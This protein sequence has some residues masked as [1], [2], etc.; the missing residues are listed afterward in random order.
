MSQLFVTTPHFFDAAD[1]R[2]FF[3]TY[4]EVTGRGKEKVAITKIVYKMVVKK[5]I[6]YLLPDGTDV[7][8][9]ATKLKGELFKNCQ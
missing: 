4:L 3:N 7:Y 8:E 1:R 9:D 2:G 6:H 5:N